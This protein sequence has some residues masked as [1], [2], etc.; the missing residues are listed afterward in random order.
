MVLVSNGGA[1]NIK[2]NHISKCNTKKNEYYNISIIKNNKI[3]NIRENG[4]L[5]TT[6]ADFETSD[7]ETDNVQIDID[8][9]HNKSQQR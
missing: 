3:L 9:A 1:F 7:G 4:F 8:E 5:N 6:S 2:N